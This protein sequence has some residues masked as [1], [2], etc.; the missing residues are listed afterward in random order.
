VSPER[1]GGMNRGLFAEPRG[2]MSSESWWLEREKLVR[3]TKP[4]L[5][6]DVI[7]VTMAFEL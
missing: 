3:R 7:K 6:R 1:A 5:E 4:L 2:G